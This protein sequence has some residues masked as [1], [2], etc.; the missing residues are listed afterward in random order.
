MN[1]KTY[2]DLVRLKTFKERF[3][4]LSLSGR[5]GY[6]T[7]GYE[8]YLNQM[9]YQSSKWRSLRNRIIIRDNGCD[10][11]VK[12]KEIGGKIYVH[13]LNPLTVEDIEQEKE[14]VY[15][16]E[17]LICSSLNTHNALHYGNANTLIPEPAIRFKNDMAPW[18]L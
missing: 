18:L 17:N 12:G 13:H 15:D 2:R 4:Y 16:P 8:R 5:V 10:L 1:V 3:D 9:L 7:F 11:G 14:C 6:A